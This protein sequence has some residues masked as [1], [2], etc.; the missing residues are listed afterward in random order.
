MRVCALVHRSALG[1]P[2]QR[3][4]LD[5]EAGI[6]RVERVYT[7]RVLKEPKKAHGSAAGCRFAPESYTPLAIFRHGSIPRSSPRSTRRAN[8]HRE[9][10]PPGMDPALRAAGIEH[11]R[12]YDCRHTF[13]SW[14]IAS[15]IQLFYLARIMGTSV[16][17]IDP[18]YA[19]PAA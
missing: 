8:R 18:T 19:Q 4:D 15:G 11:R 14:A 10:P 1:D 13:A 5:L 17:Q 6:V 7:R 9:V 16:A 12:I 3:R 2:L